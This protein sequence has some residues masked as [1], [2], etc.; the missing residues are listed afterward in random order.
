MDEVQDSLEHARTRL[1]HCRL[2]LKRVRPFSLITY[3]EEA[4]VTPFDS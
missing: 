3:T 4:P 2:G 1:S